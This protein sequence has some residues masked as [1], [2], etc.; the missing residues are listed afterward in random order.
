MSVGLAKENGLAVIRESS[1][2]ATKTQW[3]KNKT[4]QNKTPVYPSIFQELHLM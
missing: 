4:K 1:H 3:S 2:T